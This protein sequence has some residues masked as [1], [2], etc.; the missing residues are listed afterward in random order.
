MSREIVDSETKLASSITSLLEEYRKCVSNDFYDV[1]LEYVHKLQA[2]HPDLLI[3]DH[4]RQEIDPFGLLV[5][6]EHAYKMDFIITVMT[7]E[8]SSIFYLRYQMSKVPFQFDPSSRELTYASAVKKFS[9]EIIVF[10]LKYVA[11]MNVFIL[12]NNVLLYERV[13][14]MLERYRN[15]KNPSKYTLEDVQRF[16]F[17]EKERRRTVSPTGGRGR[18]ASAAVLYDG[19]EGE[20]GE[21][22]GGRGRNAGPPALDP[23]PAI[24]GGSGRFGAPGSR[25][26]SKNN[27]RESFTS[28]R[29]IPVSSS[30]K[31]NGARFRGSGTASTLTTVSISESSV[32]PSSRPI[33]DHRE[34]EVVTPLLTRM[35][36]EGEPPQVDTCCV[37]TTH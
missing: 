11:M 25:S 26:I 34:K 22:S 2:E 18:S 9:D 35:T 21:R 12:G 17:A 31:A 27:S 4:T 5:Y 19:D 14:E 24:G 7:Y 3:A 6:F 15:T 32:G 23:P 13:N 33:S 1:T 20:G 37:C 10:P 36:S 29:E 28:P 30:A 8:Y 16:K